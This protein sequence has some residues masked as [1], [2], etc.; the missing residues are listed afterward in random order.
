MTPY[1]NTDKS[2]LSGPSTKSGTD[3]PNLTS[4]KM[5]G[6]QSEKMSGYFKTIEMDPK[7]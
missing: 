4:F 1:K 2:L 5:I 6:S 7:S 3:E